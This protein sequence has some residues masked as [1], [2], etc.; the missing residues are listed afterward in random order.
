MI[1]P[2]CGAFATHLQHCWKCGV[3]LQTEPSHSGLEKVEPA[4]PYF[5]QDEITSKLN[6]VIEK[7]NLIMEVMNKGVK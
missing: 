1:C 5:T 2:K 6:E 3:D 7:V 4:A